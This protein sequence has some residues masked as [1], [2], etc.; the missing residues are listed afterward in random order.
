[1]LFGENQIH[2]SSNALIQSMMN[3]SL[4]SSQA[5]KKTQ[6]QGNSLLQKLESIDGDLNDHGF[7]RAESLTTRFDYTNVATSRNDF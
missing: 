7:T 6:E 4:Y 1:M 2:E 5:I 3:N